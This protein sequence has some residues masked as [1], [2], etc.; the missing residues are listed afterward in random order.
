MQKISFIFT[1]VLFISISCLWIF[2]SEEKSK[3]IFSYAVINS[4]NLQ[5]DSDNLKSIFSKH[6]SGQGAGT[7]TLNNGK[8]EKISIQIGGESTREVFYNT[9]KLEAVTLHLSYPTGAKGKVASLYGDSSYSREHLAYL[10]YEDFFELVPENNFVKLS[11]NDGEEKLFL[12]VE[13]I[14][15]DFFKRRKIQSVYQKA[16][17]EEVRFFINNKAYDHLLKVYDSKELLK[18]IL[19]AYL[20]DDQDGPFAQ[21]GYTEN[22]T[23]V[24]DK[25]FHKYLLIPNDLDQTFHCRQTSFHPNIFKLASY[26]IK[27]S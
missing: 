15:S 27:Y 8:K 18:Y 26:I 11:I 2:S 16:T 14:S 24:Q 7:F 6:K 19:Y 13:N 5:L 12:M 1:F 22:A 25:F 20:V 10:V 23:V 9:K 3:N 4:I 17:S 21:R